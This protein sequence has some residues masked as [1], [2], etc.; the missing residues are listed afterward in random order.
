M[1][2]RFK[3]KASGDVV[4][5][6]AHGDRVLLAMGREPAPRGIVTVEQLPGAIAAL[7]A[8]ITADEAARRARGDA[9]PGAEEDEPAA[10]GDA[11]DADG[12][13]MSLRRRAW[14]MLD[15]LQRSEAEGAVVV[16]G[17]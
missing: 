16:W 2:Y 7:Q 17:V 6:Q 11:G 12:D 9:P 8:A 15:L 5:L 4:M 1:L 14:P 3:S 10:A 13:P